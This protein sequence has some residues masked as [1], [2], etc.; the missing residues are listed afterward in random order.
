MGSILYQ[1]RQLIRWIWLLFVCAALAHAGPK[2]AGF[3]STITGGASV[4]YDTNLRANEAG[5]EDFFYNGQLDFQIQRDRSDA[6]WEFSAGTDLLRFSSEDQENSENFR[7]GL[8]FFSNQPR[9]STRLQ[10][11]GSI[12]WSRTTEADPQLGDR[13]TRNRFNLTGSALY[14]PN[15]K[16]SFSLNGS[17]GW[18]DPKPDPNGLQNL[19][20]LVR[21]SIGGTAF[22]RYSDKLAYTLSLSHSDTSDQNATA[23]LSLDNATTSLSIGV[24][25]QITP[26]VNGTFSVGWQF[27]EANALTNSDDLPYLSSGLSWQINTRNTVSANASIQFGTTL[28][29]RLTEDLSVAMNYSRVINSKLNGGATLNWTQSEQALLGLPREDESLQLGLNFS[30]TLNE[31]LSLRGTYT[32]QQQDSTDA[33]ND[34]DQQRVEL[35]LTF[36]Y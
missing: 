21:W 26:K 6:N 14:S 11:N 23:G 4:G 10:T 19:A 27:R 9:F 2:F 22:Y 15:S 5:G 30:Y 24:D 12:D 31:L 35:S 16:Y 20:E 34:F 7:A 13:I 3:K 17:Y 32:Y 36:T 29:G 28:D 8:R 18:E 33:F 1:L 25:G